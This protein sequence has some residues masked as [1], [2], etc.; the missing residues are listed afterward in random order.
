MEPHPIETLIKLV[1]SPTRKRMKGRQNKAYEAPFCISVLR[2]ADQVF[3]SLAC[4]WNHEKEFWF[5]WVLIQALLF[6]LLFTQS[7]RPMSPI[8]K[9]TLH[10]VRSRYVFNR[11]K[12]HLLYSRN[13][14]LFQ[15]RYELANVLSNTPLSIPISYK[16]VKEK[17]ARLLRMST[18]FG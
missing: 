14:S 4:F 2:K 8:Y 3:L 9:R 13:G 12:D 11:H 7:V 15:K 6:L 16:R 10:C 18:R 5:S 1:S 17:T